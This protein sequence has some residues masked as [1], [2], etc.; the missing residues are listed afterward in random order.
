MLFNIR[1]SSYIHGVKSLS[2]FNKLK[3]ENKSWS[4]SDCQSK[5]LTVRKKID[6]KNISLNSDSY[7]NLVS[8]INNIKST[9]DEIICKLN[10][11]TKSNSELEKSVNY[12]SDKVD[13][14]DSTLIKL[15]NSISEQGNRITKTE[16][17]CLNLELEM[18]KLNSHI[19][20]LEKDK[21]VNNTE[22][23][24]ISLTDN[25]NTFE[26]LSQSMADGI[27]FYRERQCAEL[28]GSEET[29]EFTRLF[30]NCLI[31]RFFGKKGFRSNMSTTNPLSKTSN[32]IHNNLDKKIKVPG[33]F[34]DFKKAFDSVNHNLLLKKLEY[35]GIRSNALNL[36]KS[37]ISDR[38]QQ[39]R[40]N[41]YL[42]T[43]RQIVSQYLKTIQLS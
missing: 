3:Q 12:C 14:F 1:F 42:V 5:N 11:L 39:V 37:F 32:F 17:R 41:G 2:N 31:L 27:K 18:E 26:V 34:L 20:F 24:G 35:S 25:E 8:S 19:N 9:L 30:N 40:I 10:T 21:L 7:N 28:G 15:S 4:C 36:I 33:I 16:S 29:E 38:P 6:M 23:N 13:S 43:Q 22:I